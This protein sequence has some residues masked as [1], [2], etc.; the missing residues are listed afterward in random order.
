MRFF[1]FSKSSPALPRANKDVESQLP[2]AAVSQESL[3]PLEKVQTLPTIPP[4][5][6]GLQAWLQI[7]CGFFLM[8]NSWGIVVSY[9][10]FQT[11]YT[12]GGITDETSPSTIAWIGSIQ[13]SLFD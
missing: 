3:P 2:T 12:T 1:G 8:L 13:V 5:D 7:L 10:S 11:Y 9:G 6:V 4:P